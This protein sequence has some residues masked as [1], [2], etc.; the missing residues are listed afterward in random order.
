MSQNPQTA[1]TAELKVA[2]AKAE[3]LADAVAGKLAVAP[4]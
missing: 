3:P 4:A 1:L 2:P